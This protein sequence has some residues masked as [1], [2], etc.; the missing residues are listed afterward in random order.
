M[1]AIKAVSDQL[2]KLFLSEVSAGACIP[3]QGQCCA[4]GK[5]LNCYGSCVST[6]GCRRYCRS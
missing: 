1:N 2:L 3:E 6:T 5:R 4:H